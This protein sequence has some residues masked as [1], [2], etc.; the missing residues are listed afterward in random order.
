MD[1]DR[2]QISRKIQIRGTHAGSESKGSREREFILAEGK[3]SRKLG[4]LQ[5]LHQPVGGSCI[6][7]SRQTFDRLFNQGDR[8]IGQL[9]KY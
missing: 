9:R 1:L 2:L 6:R 5:L 3:S 8:Q 7:L 4:R